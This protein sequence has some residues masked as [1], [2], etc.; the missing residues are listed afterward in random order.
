[1][2]KLAQYAPSADPVNLTRVVFFWLP[3]SLQAACHAQPFES[4]ALFLMS[5]ALFFVAWLVSVVLAIWFQIGRLGFSG[6]NNLEKLP[7]SSSEYELPSHFQRVQTWASILHAVTLVAQT[8]GLYGWRLGAEAQFR[9]TPRLKQLF[10]RQPGNTGKPR[11]LYSVDSNGSVSRAGRSG[12]GGARSRNN[13]NTRSQSVV[14]ARARRERERSVHLHRPG[15]MGLGAALQGGIQGGFNGLSAL[16]HGVLGGIQSGYEHGAL[17][18]PRHSGQPA[19]REEDGPPE[20]GGVLFDGGVG[21]GRVLGGVV[22]GVV[23]GLGGLATGVVGGG[24]NAMFGNGYGELDDEDD[25]DEDGAEVVDGEPLFF[26]VIT[27]IKP[28]SAIGGEDEK[29][30]EEEDFVLHFKVMFKIARA[31]YT[32]PFHCEDRSSFMVYSSIAELVIRMNV[33]AYFQFSYTIIP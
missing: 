22:G 13:N 11:V 28:T 12:G 6:D 21:N 32:S 23:G 15:Q 20:R 31:R 17:G 19:G 9:V 1:M 18:F 14:N 30:A 33:V 26:N 27:G 25:E 29:A 5:Y 7:L 16:G 4:K 2:F 10:L 3:T 24:L 8:L